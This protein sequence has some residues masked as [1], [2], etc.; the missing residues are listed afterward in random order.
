[1]A[2]RV[3]FVDDD[4]YILAA[5]K[6]QLRKQFHIDTAESPEK[7]LTALRESG[8][9]AVIVSDLRMPGMDG[10]EFL[11][12]ARE[13]TPDSVRILLTGHADLQ[14][15]MHAINS[16]NVFRLLTKPC[17]TD[18]LVDA[19][20]RGVEKHIENRQTGES[21]EADRSSHPAKKILIVDD[22]QVIRILIKDALK[23]HRELEILT[24]ENGKEAVKQ[25]KAQ[26][27]DLV[28]TDLKMPVMNGL[29]LLAFMR[30]HY[31]ELPAI[32][33]TG[34]GNAKLESRIKAY[35]T[36][37]YFEKPMD[38]GVLLEL[39]FKG[40]H[41]RAISQ[42]HGISVSAFLQLVDNEQKTCTL[43]IRSQDKTGYLY[44]SEGDLI[45][46]ET[47][48]LKAE[49][50]AYRIIGWENAVIEIENACRKKEKE[51]HMPLMMVIMESARILDEVNAVNS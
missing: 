21:A 33:L 28:V 44:L 50:A 7:G 35:E 5:F 19:L 30:Q 1:M 11:Y 43:K 48:K 18:V 34:H 9:Y 51:I 22:D 15:A 31:P 39:I 41:S 49:E 2:H 17:P 26:P 32:V 23:P 25:L 47:G 42:I 16:G 24:A 4:P 13:M 29:K 12:R 8:P 45:A 27:V 40:I 6:R 3:L 38:I 46:A 10:N 20:T 14:A 37:Q 36:F